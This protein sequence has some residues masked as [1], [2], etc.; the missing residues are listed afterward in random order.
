M[1]NKPYF[2]LIKHINS[3]KLYAGCK[4][5]KKNLDSNNLM[6]DFGYK[7]SSKVIKK[8]IEKDG[9]DSFNIIDIKHFETA[10]EAREYE[11][12]FLENVD[13]KNNQN[14][15][16]LSNSK[17]D[18]VNKGG[19]SLSK[20]T[21]EK[22]KKP[23]S[24]ETIKKMKKS[25]RQR[26]KKVYDKM[27]K[28]RKENDFWND[29]GCRKKISKANQIRFSDVENRKKHSEIM[30]KYYQENPISEE[31]RKKQSD[32]LSGKKNPMYGRKH[33]EETRLKMKAAW[34]KR[35]QNKK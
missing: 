25:L 19:Y 17:K 23:K 14:F 6:T 29:P 8:L 32:S 4:Y 5:S 16:N 22:M 18:Y 35:K 28:S 10:E 3:N 11:S 7:T 13:A 21:K 2:Y 9:L 31:T 1:K 26:P 12:N 20:K 15:I 33:N 27:V 24:E 34:E 30:I